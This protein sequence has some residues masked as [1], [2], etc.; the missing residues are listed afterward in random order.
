M[1]TLEL[2]EARV[3]RLE[4]STL[5]WKVGFF[6]LSAV[7]LAQV[8]TSVASAYENYLAVGSFTAREASIDKLQA[9]DVRADTLSVK[10]I[11]V[12]DAKG[13]IRGQFGMGIMGMGS[14]PSL[15]LKDEEGATGASLSVAKDHSSLFLGVGKSAQPSVSLWS[16]REKY[17]PSGLV[18]R[19]ENGKS[20]IELE[21]SKTTF[22]DGTFVTSSHLQ[23]KTAKEAD[24]VYLSEGPSDGGNLWLS[25]PTSLITLGH[26][27]S[28]NLGRPDPEFRMS[29]RG[30]KADIV[31]G[32]QQGEPRASIANPAGKTIWQLG[33]AKGGP[34]KG[35]QKQ[36]ERKSSPKAPSDRF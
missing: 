11:L 32:L 22:D 16:S 33:T 30:S 26:A 9:G 19:D 25:S 15:D 31:F 18:I 36:S 5:R 4:A 28:A 29:W 2:L 10:S 8:I 12:F 34:D 3:S 20:R 35:S 6:V 13:R 21:L 27:F 1:T 14:E 23:F 24:S 7:V 17:L